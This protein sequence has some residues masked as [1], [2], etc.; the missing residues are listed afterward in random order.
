MP[1]PALAA[2]VAPIV[3]GLSVLVPVL[4]VFV[5]VLV[6]VVVVSSVVLP[7]AVTVSDLSIEVESA[8]AEPVLLQAVAAIMDPATKYN[9]TFFI[10]FKVY[11]SCFLYASAIGWLV[12]VQ[13]HFLQITLKHSFSVIMGMGSTI[14]PGGLELQ[15]RPLVE[16]AHLG[17][18]SV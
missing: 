3:P 2:P 12:F 6:L 5:V 7:G 10:A 15:P 13:K 9:M 1:V 17:T 11:K 8:V 16:E 4:S 14:M 18:T